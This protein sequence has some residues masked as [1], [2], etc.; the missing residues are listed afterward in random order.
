M[1]ETHRLRPQGALFRQG[2]VA[3]TIFLTPVFAVLY[4]LT[5]PNGA[6]RLVV[7]VHISSLV[8]IG[9]ATALFFSAGIQVDSNG[10]RERGYFGRV[11]YVPVADIGEVMLADTFT[12]RAEEATPQLFVCDKQ[13]KQLVR[14]RG[15]FWSRDSMNVVIAVLGVHHTT[16]DEAMS[17]EELRDAYPGLLYWFERRPVLVGLAFTA[18]TAIFGALTLLVL[19]LL[20]ISTS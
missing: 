14:M 9:I 11:T 16:L 1:A 6:W 5:I 17:H 19:N 13:G 15:Q 10:L 18:A 8:V 7:F 2:L 4:V 20:G 12:G 3:C